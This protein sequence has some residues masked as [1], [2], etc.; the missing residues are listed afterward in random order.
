MPKSADF[1]HL[2]IVTNLTRLSRR[3]KPTKTAIRYLCGQAAFSSCTYK[4][5]KPQALNKCTSPKVVERDGPS[6][7]LSHSNAEAHLPTPQRLDPQ[8]S[9]MDHFISGKLLQVIDVF[10]SAAGQFVSLEISKADN[11]HLNSIEFSDDRG[12]PTLIEVHTVNFVH[13][14]NA[15]RR[16][17]HSHDSS[18]LHKQ[19]FGQIRGV[20]P[21]RSN[22][23]D[24]A[25][26]VIRGLADPDIHIAG[27]PWISVKANSETIG[28]HVINVVAIQQ[29]QELAEVRRRTHHHS[30]FSAEPACAEDDTLE[31]SGATK[32]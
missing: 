26:R 17:T 23:S 5:R 25:S 6:R 22:R 1:T 9:R 31:F 32:A 11:R 10:G 15:D 27:G 16:V 29:F 30:S 8:D 4:G 3:Q 24:D 20:K 12:G 14:L 19:I 2:T 13:Q 28:E 7:R 21:K 18:P